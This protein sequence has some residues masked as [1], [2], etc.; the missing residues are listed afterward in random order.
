[1]KS[2]LLDR[3]RILSQSGA[4]MISI[5]GGADLTLVDVQK[6]MSQLTAMAKPGVKLFMGAT[7]DETWQNRIV[8]TVLAAENWTGD[9]GVTARPVGGMEKKDASSPL[10]TKAGAKP[11]AA[12]PERT[13]QSTLNFD[14]GDKG[15]F[16]NVEPTIYDGEDLDIPTFIRRGI[17]LSFEK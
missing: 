10:D 1:M 6:I 5:N 17:K 3:G 14:T 9:T 15:R 12:P 4:L 7:V 13:I 11:V 8:L 2:P 16:K